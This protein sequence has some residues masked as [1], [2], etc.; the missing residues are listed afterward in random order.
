MEYNSTSLD[1]VCAALCYA[2]GIEPPAN[3]AAP[4]GIITNYV[5]EKL[6]GGKVDRIVKPIVTR[7]M[8]SE[9][10]TSAGV[11]RKICVI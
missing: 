6:K 4:N 1:T 9:G 10:T 3:S 2:M 8:R 5:D 11:K 7:T